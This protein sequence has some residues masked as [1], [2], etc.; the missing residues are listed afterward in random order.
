MARG[1]AVACFLAMSLVFAGCT[2]KPKSGP[3]RPLEAT[4]N[5]PETQKQVDTW[6]REVRTLVKAFHWKLEPC[7]GLEWKV[8]GQSVNGRPLVYA[9]FGNPDSKNVSLILAGV[10]GDEITPQY[11]GFKLARWLQERKAELGDKRV[12][13]APMVNP[14]G[15]LNPKRTR[16]NANGVDVN[17]NFATGDWNERALPAWKK[18]FRSDP[19]RFPGASAASEPETRFQVDLIERY[20]PQKILSIHSPLNFIDYDGPTALALARFRHEY[21]RE[22]LKLRKSLKAVSG[23]FFPGSLGNFSGQEKG[24]P[25]L[26]LELPSADARKAEQYWVSFSRGIRTMIDFVVP[27]AEPASTPREKG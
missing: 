1:W 14:D 4:A 5:D 20:K 15:F 26:T 12:I 2:K 25:T 27:P 17:R 16:V 9:E 23:G 10:H 7:E 19:R 18:R 22:C 21:V 3:A 6:C 8:G 24:I 11:L 13:V